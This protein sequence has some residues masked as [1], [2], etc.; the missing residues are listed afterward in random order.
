MTAPDGQG[1]TA[2]QH[3]PKPSGSD[4]WSAGSTWRRWDP[5][6]HLPGTALNDQ[7]DVGMSVANALDVLASREPG[8]EVVGVTDY[9]TT[10][11]F[12]KA[13]EAWNEGA[14]ASIALLFPNVELRLS[15]GTT[16]GKGVNVHLLCAPEEVDELDRFLENLE[17]KAD[18]DTFRATRSDLIRLG[19][20]HR[21]DGHLEEDAAFSLG[22][23]QFKVDLETL[24]SRAKAS[25]WFGRNCLIAVASGQGDGTSGVR[26]PD[27]SFEQLRQEIERLADIIFSGNPADAQFWLG[28]S[29]KITPDQLRATR[30]GVKPCIHGSDAHSAEKLGVPDQQRCTWINGAPTFE[31]LRMACLSPATRVRIGQNHPAGSTAGRIVSLAVDATWFPNKG[32]PINTG[33]VAIIGPRGSGKTALADL[34]A[35]GAGAIEP[36]VN[37]RS[38]LARAKD[39]LEVA[40]TKAVVSWADGY[41]TDAPLGESWDEDPWAREPVRYLSQQF[42]DELCA[43]DGISNRLLEEIERVVFEARPR[44]ERHGATSFHELLDARIRPALIRMDSAKQSVE[45]LNGELA[46]LRGLCDKGRALKMELANLGER[47]GNLDKSIAILTGKGDAESARR[48]TLVSQALE[49]REAEA[50]LVERRTQALQALQAAV[51]SHADAEDRRVNQ[52]WPRAY[53]DAGLTP[54]EWALFQLQPVG[55][56]EAVLV[57][58]LQRATGDLS[59]LQ[60]NLRSD[61]PFDPLDDLPDGDLTKRTIAELRAERARLQNRLNLDQRRAGQLRQKSEDRG[62]LANRLAKVNETLQ[63]I[64]EAPGVEAALIG[65]RRDRYSEY[66]DALLE[67]EHHLTDLYT[68]LVQVLGEAG[69]TA[70]KLEFS[71][72]RIVDFDSWASAGEAL[73]DLRRGQRLRGSGSL[74]A[75]AEAALLE[76]WRG[77]SGDQVAAALT[78]FNATHASEMHQ[79]ARRADGETPRDWGRR[80]A[81]WLFSLDHV[82]LSYSLRYDG[83]EIERLSPGT[84]GIVLL[85]LYLAIDQQETDPLLIDQPEENLD[86]ES[87]YTE[88]VKLFRAASSRRQIIMVTHNANLVVNTDVD[89]VIVARADHTA[90]GELPALSYR[91]GG[92]E[93]PEIRRAVCEVLEGGEA[94]FRE[95]ARRLGLEWHD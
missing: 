48:F 15:T 78:T 57:D 16:A 3:E 62:T 35:A 41:E 56:P 49:F 10:A 12:R 7:Y 38:F 94:A 13:V 31:T 79:Q 2:V 46:D 20:H 55:D 8:I 81:D 88:L 91:S 54:D 25:A 29:D 30:G 85:L 72:R 75:L 92:M 21:D 77:G 61:I 37:Q 67:Q 9:C 73:V 43:A 76:V 5:H 14:G 82:S 42:V 63:V 64:E 86:P 26:T 83:V 47:L 44:E 70:S 52:E 68:P 66:F 28:Q 53:G 90:D 24:K 74:A 40:P 23:N 59:G 60:G 33:L 36:F 80:V 34:I 6:V 87:V 32:V 51:R 58:A 27:G 18:G 69:G 71:V 4:S 11:S 17:F 89:Q 65:Q 50:Q 95:R 84:R 22:V 1:H 93:D 19:R 45:R 39:R